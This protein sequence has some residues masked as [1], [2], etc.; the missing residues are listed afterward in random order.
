[1]PAL[2]PAMHGQRIKSWH[3]NHDGEIIAMKTDK[4]QPR[5][6]TPGN[7]APTPP[8]RGRGP[9]RPLGERIVT[10]EDRLAKLRHNAELQVLRAAEKA[11]LFDYKFTAAQ[12]QALMQ[13]IVSREPRPLSLLQRK[14]M[15]IE[16]LKTRKAKSKRQDMGRTKALIGSFMVAQWRHKTDLHAAMAPDLRDHL[17]AHP[18]PGMAKANIDFMAGLLA[19]PQWEENADTNPDAF[20]VGITDQQ[21]RRNQSRRLILIG[22]WVLDRRG[23]L[24]EVDALIRDELANFLKQD[25]APERNVALLRDALGPF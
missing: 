20:A 2:V 24:A 1:M 15:E 6:A 25:R 8:R 13:E 14:R 23:E 9:G 22:A 10:M 21:L 5:T 3:R 12:L 16:Q 18:R 19:D 7:R 11:R 17:A 4:T